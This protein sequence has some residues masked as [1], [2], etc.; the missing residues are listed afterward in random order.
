MTFSNHKSTFNNRK[1]TLS[2]YFNHVRFC[3]FAEL[4]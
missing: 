3:T 4:L 1:M 2:Q